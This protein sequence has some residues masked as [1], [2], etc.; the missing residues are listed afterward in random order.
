[1][2]I[3]KEFR[4]RFCYQ[5]LYTENLFFLKFLL[6][7]LFRSK[8]FLVLRMLALCHDVP[9]LRRMSV[10]SQTV[11]VVLGIRMLALCHDVPD[12]ARK[13]GFKGA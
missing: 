11:V 2:G 9:D 3:V 1:M 7:L 12:L 10:L 4:L 6:V 8:Q 5:K 13:S